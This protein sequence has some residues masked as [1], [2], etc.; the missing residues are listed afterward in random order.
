MPNGYGPAMR[1]FTKL[2]KSPFVFLR[3]ERYLFII[4]VG[5]CYLQS[6]SFT[7]V[8][9]KCHEDNKNSREPRF[10]NY[11]FGIHNFF[12]ISLHITNKKF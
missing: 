9:K 12:A 11:F 1:A 8:A 3:Y 7:E 10:S 6:D 2:L 4:F 5:D